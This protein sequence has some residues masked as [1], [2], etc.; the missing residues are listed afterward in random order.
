MKAV[1]A[2][3]DALRVSACWRSKGLSTASTLAVFS[4]ARAL[5]RRCCIVRSLAR[6]RD[7]CAGLLDNVDRN[8]ET[9]LPLAD[10]LRIA[11]TLP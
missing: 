3:R 5:P 10:A 7:E 1:Q 9:N 6:R 8:D 2:E 11:Q 4:P